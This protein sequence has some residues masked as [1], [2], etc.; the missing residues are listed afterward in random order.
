M[1]N[2]LIIQGGMGVA[3]SGWR[4]ARTV[5]MQGELGVVSGTSIDTVFARLLENGDPQ[6]VLR[7]AIAAFPD[8]E[9]A[10]RVLKKYFRDTPVK[11][12]HKYIGRPLPGARLNRA[13]QELMVLANFA[14]VYLAK[15]G[16][17]GK[18][19]INFLEKLQVTTLPSLYGALLAGVDYVI[20]GAGIPREIPGSL[21]KL[22]QHEDASL[23]LDVSGAN[24]GD[25]FTSQFSPK[26]F[27]PGNWPQLKRPQFLAIISSNVLALTLKK[28]SNGKVN[29][30]IVERPVAG[31]HNAPPRG[32][33]QYNELV[34][35]FMVSVMK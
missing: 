33:T 26:T 12:G 31:G 35:L 2:P 21:D 6:G 27:M 34:S 17:L 20:M 5:S 32:E 29:G 10:E 22:S 23:K 13:Q 9:M 28:K 25:N 11:A 7:K 19:G 8:R 3:I 30:F 24:S 1:K 14:E 16:H 4:L 18:V 15:A